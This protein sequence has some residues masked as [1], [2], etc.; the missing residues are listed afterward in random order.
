MRENIG[1]PRTKGMHKP[2]Q[3]SF[4]G[5]SLVAHFVDARNSWENCN[6]P[7]CTIGK[8]GLFFI[9]ISLSMKEERFN[10]H[11]VPDI[12]KVRLISH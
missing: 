10:G 5:D 12:R 4:P 1:T 6:F 11:Q 9:K 3:T 2:F 7:K 8:I